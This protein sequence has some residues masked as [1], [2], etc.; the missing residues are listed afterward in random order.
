M[1]LS[2]VQR[3]KKITFLCSCWAGRDNGTWS[4]GRTCGEEGHPV[5]KLLI[6]CVTLN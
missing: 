4:L 1:T 5:P 3:I 2:T 6:I